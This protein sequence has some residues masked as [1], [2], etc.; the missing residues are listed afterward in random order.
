MKR[1]AGFSLLEVLA[2]LALLAI[3]LLGVYAGIRSATLSVQR[4]QTAIERLDAVR[5]AR[6][7]LRRELAAAQAL[8]WKLDDRQVPVVFTGS[9]TEIRFVAPLPGYLN[10]LAPQVQIIRVVDNHDGGHRLEVLFAPVP[11]SPQALRPGA[12]EV[13]LERVKSV[14]FEF[15][16]ARA[17]EGWAD[18]WDNTVA[19]PAA[20]RIT[21]IPED[22]EAA[23]PALVVAPRQSAGGVNVRSAGRTLMPDHAP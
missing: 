8:P 10:K 5:G 19:L 4:G 7:F 15:A 12:P 11:L 20:V 14:R 18:H 2:A 6:E 17:G 13:L 16:S 3:L 23:W 22:G 1:Q 21:V 9:D